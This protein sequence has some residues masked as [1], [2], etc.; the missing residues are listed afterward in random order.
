MLVVSARGTP[1]GS[2]SVKALAA[3]LADTVTS[4]DLDDA[5]KANADRGIFKTTDT[6]R[7]FTLSE[8]EPAVTVSAPSGDLVLLLY[9]RLSPEVVRVDGDRA[10]LDEFLA[11][12]E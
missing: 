10:A 5:F 1:S 3:A 7:T 4:T 8:G 12:I 6:G 9:K 2:A 11:P